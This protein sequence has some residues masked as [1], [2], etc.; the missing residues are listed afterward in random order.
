MKNL[1]AAA[2]AW[3]VMAA[4]VP[5]AAAAGREITWVG[6]GISKLGFMRDLAAEYEKRTGV[7]IR[8]EGGGA[9]RGI[10]QVAAGE[11]TL[12]GSCRLP[13][14]THGAGS[15]GSVA[16]Q[17]SNIKLV[18]LGWDALVVIVHPQNRLIDQISRDQLRDLLT[19][20]ITDWSQLAAGTS[21]AI[22]LYV[23]R[24]KISGVGLTLRQQLFNNVDQEFAPGAIV[25]KSSGKIEKAVEQDP[26]GIAVSGISS[27]RHRNLRMVP[28]DGVEP[29][30][31]NLKRGKYPLYRVLF[32][33][34]PTDYLLDPD[35]KAF[36]DFALSS[37]GQ[38]VIEHAGTLPYVKGIGL[39]HRTSAEYIDTIELVDQKGIYTLGGH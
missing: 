25:L 13:L 35:L 5:Q 4:L 33:V 22:N 23:R 18:P 21:H 9:T 27:S 7:R 32:L 26:W 38:R 24:G 19:G 8:L 12:G 10:R 11:S 30:L 16:A 39:L 3:V 14:V 6:C 28:L 29:T 31:A 37:A 1:A 34:T 20:K 2:A 15:A 17:E 36:V